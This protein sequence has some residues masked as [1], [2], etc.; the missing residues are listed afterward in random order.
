MTTL[1]REP[2]F[3]MSGANLS[4][5]TIVGD[6][7]ALTATTV[8]LRYLERY[9]AEHNP[10]HRVYVQKLTGPPISTGETSGQTSDRAGHMKGPWNS[11]ETLP[12][13]SYSR[14]GR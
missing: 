8:E 14:T 5:I 6:I 3:R 2:G 13:S 9:Q 1:A 10:L 4:S 11:L 7:T 12:V